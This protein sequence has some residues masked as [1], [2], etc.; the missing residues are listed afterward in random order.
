MTWQLSL[1]DS[2]DDITDDDA[3]LRDKWW[4]YLLGKRKI[5]AQECRDVFDDLIE[6]FGRDEA[7]ERSKALEVVSGERR[8]SGWSMADVEILG[9][10]DKSFDYHTVWDRAWAA[11]KG[12]PKKK[13]AKLLAWDYGC[14]GN[15]V[16]TS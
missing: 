12:M 10:F 13:V 15:H 14:K 2:L 9:L 6:T 16:F 11:R 4:A 5:D 3:E 8:A 1:F 7:F